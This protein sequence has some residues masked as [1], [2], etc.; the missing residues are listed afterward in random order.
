MDYA[1][2]KGYV[3][4]AFNTTD[5]EMTLAIVKAFDEMKIGGY[6]QISSNNLKLSNP[7]IIGEI[8]RMIFERENIDTPIAL[9]LDHGR[10]F[11]DVKDCI[12][13]G[14]TSVMMDASGLPYEDN[15]AE[16]KRA[17]EY[18]HYF[19]IPVEAELGGIKGKEDDHVADKDSKTHVED[20]L[21][22][23]KKTNCDSLAVS[24]GNVHGLELTP[25]LDFELMKQIA[26]ISPVP[27]VLHG[28]SGIPFDKVRTAKQY[29]L[30]KVNYG[31]DLRKSY[32][33]TFGQAYDKNNNEFNLIKLASDGVNNVTKTAK[34]IIKEV[35]LI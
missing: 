29:N 6:V 28:G 5:Y 21:D 17:T 27:L 8:T 4:P 31:S 15:I 26:E 22:F 10:S 7:K 9:H 13:A 3:L 18:S 33:K 20:V 19:G 25:D 30:V 34:K 32:I 12:D 24:V 1:I 16:V 11:E 23:V 35:N 2:K 14:F